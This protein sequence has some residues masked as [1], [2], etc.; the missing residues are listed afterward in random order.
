MLIK[1]SVLIFFA[2]FFIS[3]HGEGKCI[4]IQTFDR[5]QTF[6]GFSQTSSE[7]LLFAA[8]YTHYWV[9]KED[10]PNGSL[11][12]S[13]APHSRWILDEPV[14]RLSNIFSISQPSPICQQILASAVAFTQFKKCDVNVDIDEYKSNMKPCKWFC[15]L[16]TE[17]VEIATI[18]TK[19]DRDFLRNYGIDLDDLV[20]PGLDALRCDDPLIWDQ[21]NTDST[22]FDQNNYILGTEFNP[23]AA[24]QSGS[25]V[26]T[27]AFNP[28]R[29]QAPTCEAYRGTACSSVFPQGTMVYVPSGVTIEEMES[30]TSFSKIIAALPLHDRACAHNLIRYACTTLFSECL[31]ETMPR[32]FNMIDPVTKKIISQRNETIP[33]PAPLHTGVDTCQRYVDNCQNTPYFSSPLV[34]QY[35]TIPDCGSFEFLRYNQCFKER[36]ISEAIDAPNNER[37]V[38]QNSNAMGSLQTDDTDDTDN[39]DNTDGDVVKLT[40]AQINRNNRIR[41]IYDFNQNMFLQTYS[42]R[43]FNY[44][45]P[46]TT[47]GNVTTE[48]FTYPGTIFP[49]K[50]FDVVPFDPFCPEPLVIPAVYLE[51]DPDVQG[52]SNIFSGMFSFFVVPFVCVC[53]FFFFFVFLFFLFIHIESSLPFLILS[54]QTHFSPLH[55][56][57]PTQANARSRVPPPPSQLVTISTSNSVPSSSTVSLSSSA[58][59]SLSHF[60][61]SNHNAINGSYFGTL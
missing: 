61:F 46:E 52:R 12:D 10:T 13:C 31:T 18:C 53:V 8:D 44:F 16:I 34:S 38:A 39:T 33:Y 2:L 43:L 50:T 47:R 49:V 40:M 7:S 22:Q 20:N 51:D 4:E 55:S 30:Y 45:G 37:F 60:S 25:C 26:S 59:S 29:I 11:S 42:Y 3:V 1:I 57:P 28:S 23:T 5:S 41:Q 58:R 32:T 19:N 15:E 9:E 54:K 21:N 48:A 56:F 14:R 17:P 6:Y 27:V 24:T 35:F 36:D